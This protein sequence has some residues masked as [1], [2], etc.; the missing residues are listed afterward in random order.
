MSAE[1]KK[2]ITRK[3]ENLSQWYIDVVLNC[4]LADY[5]PVKGCMVIRPYGWAIW[6]MVR[7]LL[8]K[9]IVDTGHV[10]AQFILMRLAQEK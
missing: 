8:N 9:R 3:S 4:E 2:F 10:N 7:E 1:E 6:E 5:A